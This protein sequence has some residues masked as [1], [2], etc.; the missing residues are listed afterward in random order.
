MYSINWKTVCH[1]ERN[2][3]SRLGK[4]FKSY[5]TNGCIRSTVTQLFW[6]YT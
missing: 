1:K 6:E 5:M 4:H 2:S 3:R